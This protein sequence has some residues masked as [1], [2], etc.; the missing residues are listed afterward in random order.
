MLASLPGCPVLEVIC[1]PDTAPSK[2]FETFEF[3]CFVILS[4]FIVAAEP[5]K[6]DFLAVPYATTTTSSR[7]SNEIT[8]VFAELKPYTIH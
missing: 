8:K 1:T 6:E 3:C 2:A 7:V 5:V 4:A